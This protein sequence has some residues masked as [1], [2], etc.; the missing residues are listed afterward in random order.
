MVRSIPYS[1]IENISIW[2]KFKVIGWHHSFRIRIIT[3]NY[4]YFF[5]VR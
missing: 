4:I 1:S 3:N 5:Q 2:S